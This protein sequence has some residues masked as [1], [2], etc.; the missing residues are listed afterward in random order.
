V[1]ASSPISEQVLAV[2]PRYHATP[3]RPVYVIHAGTRAVLVG[4]E[5]LAGPL[6]ALV[7]TVLHRGSPALAAKQPAAVTTA[8]HTY[9]AHPWQLPDGHVSPAQ[10]S[11]RD[12]DK[13]R[14]AA[15]IGDSRLRDLI[16]GFHQLVRR[17]LDR[18][19]G[20]LVDTTGDRALA[21]SDSPARGQRLRRGGPRRS[22]PP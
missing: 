15:Q 22:N 2:P 14:L 8:G 17:Q 13:R 16:D 3:G 21:L 19:Q 1:A 18:Y 20:R 10:P 4:E 12:P 6:H 9:R 11:P 7:S 5:N